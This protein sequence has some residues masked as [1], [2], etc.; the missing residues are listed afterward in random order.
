MKLPLAGLLF[1]GRAETAVWAVTCLAVPIVWGVVVN[2]LFERLAK[3]RGAGGDAA[4]PE[5]NI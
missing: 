2:W 5:Y 1:E 4:P 3:R